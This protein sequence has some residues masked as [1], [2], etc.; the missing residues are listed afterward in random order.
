[1]ARPSTPSIRLRL[2]RTTLAF[3]RQAGNR[4]WQG[5][6]PYPEIILVKKTKP[7]HVI[8]IRQR[9]DELTSQMHHDHI[10]DNGPFGRNLLP[11]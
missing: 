7:G 2:R 8:S 3:E 4:V 9:K 1:M 5:F 6:L 10:V 11:A